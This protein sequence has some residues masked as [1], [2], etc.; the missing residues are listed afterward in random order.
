M[1]SISCYYAEAIPLPAESTVTSEISQWMLDT[2]HNGR[3]LYLRQVFF[4]M[5]GE[6]DGWPRLVHNLRAEVDE[7]LMGGVS[8]GGVVAVW[9]WTTP[10]GGLKSWAI[11]GLRVIDVPE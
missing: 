11:G 7:G 1:E 5:A 6:K 4:P 9:G 3:S 10:A 2:G 8:W